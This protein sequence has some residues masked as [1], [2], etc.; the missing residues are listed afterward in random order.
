MAMTEFVAEGQGAPDD[1]SMVGYEL[2]HVRRDVGRSGGLHGIYV[3][4]ERTG[5]AGDPAPAGTGPVHD[6][7]VGRGRHLPGADRVAASAEREPPG[8]GRAHRVRRRTTT[9]RR[10]GHATAMLGAVLPIAHTM[11]IDPVLVT[12]DNDNEP[13]RRTIEHYGGVLEDERWGYLR[14]RVPTPG[15]RMALG[16]EPAVPVLV[17][18]EP[19]WASP[20]RAL[21]HAGRDLVRRRLPVVLHRQAPLRGG[22]RGVR[23]HRDEVEVVWRA[24]QLDPTARRAADSPRRH[25]RR[26][27]GTTRSSRSRSSA[28][29]T[30]PSSPAPRASSTTSSAPVRGNTFDAHRAAAPRARARRSRTP[31][32]ERLLRRLLHGGRGP[33]RGDAGPLAAEVGLDP[34]EAATAACRPDATPRPWP[35]TPRRPSLGVRGVPFFVIDRATHRGRPAGGPLPPGARPGLDG[36]PPPDHGHEPRVSRRRPVPRRHLCRLTPVASVGEGQELRWA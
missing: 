1:H 11:G 35:T 7:V 23:R 22:P 24:F 25:A 6:L 16:N 3:R 31:I 12:C 26:K 30:S 18:H 5:A 21:L 10:R 4:P 15:R 20:G 19:S 2:P 34:E 14:H 27:Y 13:S 36:V 29:A 9:A 32:K 28:S 17:A 33:R 8:G